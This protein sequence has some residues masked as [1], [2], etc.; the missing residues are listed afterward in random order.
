VKESLT[1]GHGGELATD[2]LEELLDGGAV[3]DKGGGN[4][5]AL[6]DT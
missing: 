6:G 2:T 4:L 5:E 3:A 1:P